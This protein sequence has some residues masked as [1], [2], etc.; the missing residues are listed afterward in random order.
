[1]TVG[2]LLALAVAMPIEVTTSRFPIDHT[3]TI[4]WL[5]DLVVGTVLATLVVGWVYKD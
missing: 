5:A 4:C 1:L 3:F 2:P